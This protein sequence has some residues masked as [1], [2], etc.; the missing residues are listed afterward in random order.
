M[1]FISLLTFLC[2]FLGAFSSDELKIT[3]SFKNLEVFIPTH[4]NFQPLSQVDS[5]TLTFSS[6]LVGNPFTQELQSP[7]DKL[8][9]SQTSNKAQIILLGKNPKLSH[10]YTK[11]GVVLVF[12]SE[13]YQIS[14]ARYFIV[15]TIL[16][17][18]II[19]LFFFKKRLKGKVSTHSINYQEILLKQHTKLIKLE[20]EGERYLIFSNQNGCVLLNHY[21]KT[22]DNK[23]FMNLIK[24]E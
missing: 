8:I 11:E 12:T 13:I 24:E 10:Q 23:E 16:L 6:P 5:L 20:Y 22:K 18:L 14:W 4:E 2:Y 19:T 21:P 3:Q 17:V 1:R 7:F 15:L 9:I